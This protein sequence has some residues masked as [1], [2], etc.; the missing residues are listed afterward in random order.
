MLE[1]KNISYKVEDKS[2]LKNVSLSFESDKIYAITGPNGSGKSSVAKIIAGIYKQSFGTIEID[3]MGIDSLDITTRAR[4]YIAYSFQNPALFKGIS[5]S[6]LL[7]ISMEN[8]RNELNKAE[9]LYCVGL[10]ALDYLDRTIDETLSGGELKRIEI[11][12]V[13]ARNARIVILDE[14]EAG[15]DLWSFKQLIKT[16]NKMQ[17]KYKTTF[18]II[19]HQEKLLSIADH[20]IFLK[21][22]T[23]QTVYGKRSFLTDLNGECDCQNKSKYIYKEYNYGK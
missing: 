6:E 17:S 7:D 3:G 19:S 9:L 2:I 8:S 23:V 15:I 4:H 21:E 5:V 18:L 11:A 13:L 14:P 20:V 10:P 12:S 16:F 22:G 1:L